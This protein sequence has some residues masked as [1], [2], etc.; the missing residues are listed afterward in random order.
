M[1]SFSTHGL[2]VSRKVSF[3]NEVSSETF[4]AMEVAPR[5]AHAFD[6]QLSRVALGSLTLMDVRSAAVRIRR[7]RAHIA[8]AAEASWLLL[9]PLQR[10][11]QISISHCPVVTVASGEFCLIDHAEPYEVTHGDATRAL[12]VGIPRRLLDANPIHTER[13][14]GCVMRADSTSARLLIAVLHALGLEFKPGAAATFAPETA[15]GLWNLILAAY[16]PAADASGAQGLAARARDV[17]ADID[18]N[19]GDPRLRPAD[20]AARC[21]FSERYLRTVLQS[22]GE[23]FSEYLLRRRLEQCARLLRDPAWAARTVTEIA[24]HSGFSDATHFGRAFKTR[25]GLAPRDFRRGSWLLDE[26]RERSVIPR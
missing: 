7:T 26:A 16:S 2:P 22:S 15:Q 21:G 20:V 9:A 5:D 14:A 25:Y 23:S 4:A 24:F 17:R 13:L 10:S 12:C 1:E 11:L 3:W 6:G 8:R 19:L 18:A